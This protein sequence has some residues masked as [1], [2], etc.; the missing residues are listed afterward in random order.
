MERSLI[1]AGEEPE[2]NR[3][4]GMKSSFYKSGGVQKYF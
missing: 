1:T 4:G 2:D 3:E